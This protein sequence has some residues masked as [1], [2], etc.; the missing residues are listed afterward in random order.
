MTKLE[1]MQTKATQKAN[2]KVLRKR[3]K[4][5]ALR[6]L[7]KERPRRYMNPFICFAH[8]QKMKARN[9]H[10]LSDWKTAHK[11]LG[12]KWRALGAGRSKF[13]RQ[14]KIPAFAMFVKESPQRKE[15]LPIWRSTHKGLGAKW[16]GLDK[17]SKTKFVETSKKMKPA[18]EEH[19]KVYRKRKQDLLRQIMVA[20]K[21][22]KILKR[23]KKSTPTPKK[24]SKKPRTARKQK[25]KKIGKS[26]KPKKG[27]KGVARKINARIRMT[28]INS[29][30]ML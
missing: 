5:R 30:A 24:K 9:G 26:K 20:K 17:S 21:A 15:I 16:R 28:S 13:G 1:K 8:E 14:G 25:S 11:G 4:S 2:K 22:K 18:Y 12:A 23:Q 3:V 29:R 10:L 7:E 27:M 6:R 19:M